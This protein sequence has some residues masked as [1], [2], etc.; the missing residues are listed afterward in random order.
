MGRH[1]EGI[2]TA[3]GYEEGANWQ[4][5][6]ISGGEVLRRPGPHVGCKATKEEKEN[7]TMIIMIMILSA[8][9]RDDNRQEHAACRSWQH[10]RICTP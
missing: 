9:F 7:M 2:L 10:C 8:L 4:R 3:A 6:A 5:I 1:Q